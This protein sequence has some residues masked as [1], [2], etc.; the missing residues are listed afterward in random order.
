VCIDVL[1]GDVLSFF[2]IFIYSR[3]I[4]IQRPRYLHLYNKRV[5]HCY[6]I[7]TQCR[8]IPILLFDYYVGGMAPYL[9]CR[10]DVLYVRRRVSTGPENTCTVM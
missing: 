6:T 5:L 3:R 9:F 1:Y 10:G 2:I 4:I 7:K 8:A